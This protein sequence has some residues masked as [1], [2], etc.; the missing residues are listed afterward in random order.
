MQDTGDSLS[1]LEIPPARAALVRVS[2]K[3]TAILLIRQYKVS[4]N[5]TVVNI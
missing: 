3:K 4:T 5:N 2:V 1:E